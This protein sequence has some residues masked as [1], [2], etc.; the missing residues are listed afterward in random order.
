MKPGK[1]EGPVSKLEHVAVVW[2]Q[3]THGPLLSLGDTGTLVR[4]IPP[5]VLQNETGKVDYVGEEG[6]TDEADA[7]GIAGPEAGSFGQEGK[8]GDETT[9]IT[10]S[11]LET[12]SD[13]ATQVSGH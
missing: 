3:I 4:V 5:P 6:K 9:Q 7:D 11:D 10:E 8:S 1:S 2:I 12:G 13:G